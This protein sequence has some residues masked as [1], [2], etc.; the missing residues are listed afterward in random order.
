MLDC[1]INNC[2]HKRNNFYFLILLYTGYFYTISICVSCESIL[3]FPDEGVRMFSFLVL[4]KRFLLFQNGF[5]I[6]LSSL[7]G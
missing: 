2:E 5:S 4:V 1:R 6:S 3:S 7:I